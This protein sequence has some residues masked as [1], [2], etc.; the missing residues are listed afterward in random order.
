MTLYGSVC[1]YACLLTGTND[2]KRGTTLPTTVSAT[3][4]LYQVANATGY[5]GSHFTCTAGE[6]FISYCKPNCPD[7]EEPYTFADINVIKNNGSSV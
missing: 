2:S 6:V 7:T 3:R 4:T 5:I 1:N